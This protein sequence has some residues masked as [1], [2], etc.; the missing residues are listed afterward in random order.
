MP[1]EFRLDS[2]Q[3]WLSK[4]SGGSGE[5]SEGPRGIL[6]KRNKELKPVD[7]FFV[8]G[9]KLDDMRHDDAFSSV[10]SS[11]QPLQAS[12]YQTRSHYSKVQAR[13]TYDLEH[14]FRVDDDWKVPQE[15]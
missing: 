10:E 2:V 9:E 7:P 1:S 3:C 14:R 4:A 12:S 8:R 15:Q 5:G 13:K 6:I 11:G